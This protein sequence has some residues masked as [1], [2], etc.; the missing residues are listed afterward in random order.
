[1]LTDEESQE[2]FVANLSLSGISDFSGQCTQL[3]AILGVLGV[4]AV[5]IKLQ[6]TQQTRF[7]DAANVSRFFNLPR[8]RRDASEFAENSQRLECK[9]NYAQPPN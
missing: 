3:S 7:T 6:N 4:S 2:L 5:L 8:N 1:V 9:V